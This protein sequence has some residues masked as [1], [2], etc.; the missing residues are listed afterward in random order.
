[1]IK[2]REQISQHEHLHQAEYQAYYT[3]SATLNQA[4]IYIAYGLKPM[5]D[6][7]HRIKRKTPL[8][9]VNKSKEGKILEAKDKLFTELAL[10]TLQA[11]GNKGIGTLSEY[12]AN[13]E[14]WRVKH[15][16]C[17][18]HESVLSDIHRDF[19]DLQYT[20][21]DQNYVFAPGDTSYINIVID[22]KELMNLI[23]F[24]YQQTETTPAP[25]SKEDLSSTTVPI[26]FI[27]FAKKYFY[28]QENRK[29]TKST[30]QLVTKLQEKYLELVEKELSDNKAKVIASAIKE[31]LNEKIIRKFI[32]LRND[33]S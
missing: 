17:V 14:W 27:R 24:V 33:L 26:E 16:L 1:M 22:S 10:G 13:D 30:K 29:Y 8:Y 11:K 20:N 19:W 12:I 21:L 28:I 31:P 15:Y 2:S 18:E 6:R 4:I 25:I 5:A 32:S 3:D 7:W 9:N 23:P